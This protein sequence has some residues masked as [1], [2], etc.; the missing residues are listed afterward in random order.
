MS[1]PARFRLS[2]AAAGTDSPAMSTLMSK[3][4]ARSTFGNSSDMV[5]HCP[6]TLPET[7]TVQVSP[8]YGSGVW[9]TLQQG[10]TDV[11]LAAGKANQCAVGA[12]EDLRIHAGGAVAAQRDFD[13]VIQ[14][15]MGQ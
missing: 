5:V 1:H 7:C 4:A 11:A 13:V 14:I 10:G 3:G 12:I 15:T 2:I 8:K 9:Y 6:G